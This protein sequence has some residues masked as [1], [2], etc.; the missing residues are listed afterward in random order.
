MKALICKK[1]ALHV[2]SYTGSYAVTLS[3]PLVL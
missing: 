2:L 1:T 3:K